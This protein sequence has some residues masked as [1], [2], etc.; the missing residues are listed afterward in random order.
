MLEAVQHRLRDTDIENPDVTLDDILN[1]IGLD[2]NMYMDALKVSPHG[3]III[4]KRSPCDTYINPCNL[5]IL[6]LWGGNVDLQHVTD[7]IPT[8]MYVC[9]YMTKGKK[10]MGETLKRVAQECQNYDVQTQLNKNE[11]FGKSVLATP[12]MHACNVN[13]IDGKKAGKF[14]MLIQIC[15]MNVLVCQ[16]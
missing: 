3:L 10:A 15:K 8:I 11:F 16:S 9:I 4:L 1:Y 6:H 2:V 12:V 14:R 13:V 7:E 5:D